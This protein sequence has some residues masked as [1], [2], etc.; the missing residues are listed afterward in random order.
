MDEPGKSAE[1]DI[2]VSTQSYIT[3]VTLTNPAKR[4]AMTLAMWRRLGDVFE[5]IRNDTDTRVVILTGAGDR[6]F[7]SGNDISEFPRVRSTAGEA[8]I[9]EQVTGATYQSI[10]SLPKPVIARIDGVCVGG[11]FELAQ[12]SDMQFASTP[13]R[14]AMTPAKLGIGYKFDDIALLAEK[15][16]PRHAR[17]L[18]FT[19]RMIEA[20]EAFEMGLI[21]AVN[22]ST[23]LDSEVARVAGSIA[24]NAP[25][26]IEAIK[27]CLE[28][29]EKPAHQ[30][31]LETC[32]RLAARCHDSD[33]YL[34]GQRAFAEKRLPV[35]RAR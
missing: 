7:C 26:T 18:L 28:E 19:A 31:D 15:V 3:T 12:L 9:Y 1:P 17:D 25:L 24:A 13:S 11:G 27:F 10:R 32:A 5:D 2:G 4:N 16:G 20:R 30:R 8:A 35:F 34:E 22:E 23:E 33:D 21:T 14:F 6:A 29:Y